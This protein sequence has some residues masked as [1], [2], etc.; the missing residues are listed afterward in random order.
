MLVFL[1]LQL[2]NILN[3]T[4]FTELQI[5]LYL[6]QH[7]KK[8]LPNAF[9]VYVKKVLIQLENRKNMINIWGG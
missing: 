8:L 1:M 5:E 9:T 6:A 2:W 3:F 7:S 4:Y